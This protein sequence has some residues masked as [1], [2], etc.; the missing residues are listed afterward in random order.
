ML[1]VLF[2]FYHPSAIVRIRIFPRGS[3]WQFLLRIRADPERTLDSKLSAL[4]PLLFY[5][6]F[7]QC[8]WR[9]VDLCG[10]LIKIVRSSTTVVVLYVHMFIVSLATGR[11]VRADLAMTGEISLRG[12]V[13]P[14][15]GIKEKVINYKW[16]RNYL[17]RIQRR[18]FKST[19]SR[20]KFRIRHPTIILNIKKNEPTATVSFKWTSHYISV[21]LKQ[22]LSKIWINYLFILYFGPDPDLKQTMLDSSWPR[23]IT[24]LKCSIVV[25]VI[26][27]K[28]SGVN[29]VVLPKDNRYLRIN[30]KLINTVPTWHKIIIVEEN[31]LKEALKH[32]CYSNHLF[33][34]LLYK[35]NIF[36]SQNIF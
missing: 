7:V 11:P 26:A 10:L 14:V 30:K 8:C 35:F 34:S 29:T 4:Q 13:L 16:T 33:M 22:K 9:R 32:F 23:F 2:L 5:C 19:G 12:K 20:K 6:T 25:Q 31:S 15:G 36:I 21:Q 1:L 18:L 27:A 3:G 28:R 24:L 17:F